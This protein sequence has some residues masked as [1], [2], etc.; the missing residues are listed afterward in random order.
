[1]IDFEKEN[2]RV[3]LFYSTD[4]PTHKWVYHELNKSGKVT[5]SKVFKFSPKELRSA[6]NEEDEEAP[7]EFE[8]AFKD[9]EYY[10][11]TKD[12]LSIKHD[13]YVHGDVK[14]DRKFFVAERITYQY[15]V[16]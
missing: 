2:N 16:K 8:V 9:G 11:F 13:L 10:Q 1:M 6:F 12:I 3:I 7:V 15:F 14:I 5:I 4:Y